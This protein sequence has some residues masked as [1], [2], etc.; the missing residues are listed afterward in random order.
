MFRNSYQAGYFSILYS[1]GRKP[2]ENWAPHV[3][4]GHIKRITDEDIN[5]AALEVCGVNVSTTYVTS[6]ADPKQTL[7][8]RG[9]VLAM[10][11]KN[12]S[13]YFT[14]EVEI[15]D[16]QNIKRRFRA[17]NYN[18]ATKVHPFIC[19]MPLHLDRGWNEVQFNLADFVKRAY[20]TNYIE[21][22][23]ISI[24]AN[25][26]IR[27]IFFSDHLYIPEEA[28]AEY[29]IILNAR[30]AVLPGGGATVKSSM[31]ALRDG[32]VN[33]DERPTSAAAARAA[34]VAELKQRTLEE[35]HARQMLESP[36]AA[37][38]MLHSP[39]S[40]G[41]FSSPISLSSFYSEVSTAA[42]QGE[43]SDAAKERRTSLQRKKV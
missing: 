35:A 38:R 14:F 15:L 22:C 4:N 34:A 11:I 20:G 1:I 13:K 27:R 10:L 17:S 26:R 25:C 29:R 43:T 31:E 42:S 3:R 40:E 9:P 8:I 30:Q 19:T 23:R 12:L 7:G 37:S 32:R 39:A 18:T 36:E 6:P 33:R 41:S 24:H 2:L 21:T 16:D 28:P 5:S